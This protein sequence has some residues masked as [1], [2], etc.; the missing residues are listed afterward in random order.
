MP[1]GEKSLAY[2]MRFRASDRTLT[3]AETAVAKQAAV[4]EAAKRCGARLRDF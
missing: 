4:D 2:A 3:D 1:D